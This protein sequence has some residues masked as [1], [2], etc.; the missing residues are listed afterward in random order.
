MSCTHFTFFPLLFHLYKISIYTNTNEQTNKR[1]N[2]QTKHK[3]SSNLVFCQIPNPTKVYNVKRLVKDTKYLSQCATFSGGSHG[4]FGPSFIGAIVELDDQDESTPTQNSVFS[5]MEKIVGMNGNSCGPIRNNSIGL[6]LSAVRGIWGIG[7]IP[8]SGY[9][10]FI[11]ND[12]LDINKWPE[13]GDRMVQADNPELK[14][15]A[16][17]PDADTGCVCPAYQAELPSNFNVALARNKSDRYSISWDGTFGKNTGKLRLGD[18]IQ[19]TLNNTDNS[20]VSSQQM[21]SIDALPK[22]ELHRDSVDLGVLRTNISR[23]EVNDIDIPINITSYY[24]DTGS[25]SIYLPSQIYDAIK[26]EGGINITNITFF[27]PSLTGVGEIKIDMSTTQELMNDGTFVP[28]REG[29]GTLIMGLNIMRY[30]QTIEFSFAPNPSPYMQILPRS[31]HLLTPIK[32]ILLSDNGVAGSLTNVS[33][34]IDA[35]KTPTI[36]T[37][38]GGGGQSMIM[39]TMTMKIFIAAAVVSTVLLF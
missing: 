17:C 32:E 12:E 22:I 36:T 13:K 27:I 30:A 19:S 26:F 20:D 29:S 3:G 39:T 31:P 24:V 9:N 25:P 18:N 4:W 38:G 16:I 7:G 6:E 8:G 15:A 11:Y 21:S 23:I 10:N 28:A 35:Y 14:G 37:S 2:K 33:F 5:V 34:D 1:T